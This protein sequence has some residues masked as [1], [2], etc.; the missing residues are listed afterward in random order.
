MRLGIVRS[1]TSNHLVVAAAAG[2]VVGAVA[3][4]CET[5]PGA[6]DVDVE[7]EVPEEIDWREIGVGDEAAGVRAPADDELRLRGLVEDLDQEGVLT[8]RVAGSVVLIETVGEPPLHVVG[9][10]VAMVV[11]AAEA[12]PTGV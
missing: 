4:R 3:W 2:D 11:R 8:L 1:G 7:L 12:Y 9:D 10:E 6:R 5:P